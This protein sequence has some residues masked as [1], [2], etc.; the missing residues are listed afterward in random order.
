LLIYR[1][2]FR[3][4]ARPPICRSPNGKNMMVGM[5][6]ILN[7]SILVVD[8]QES[9]VSLL[10]QLLSANLI[11]SPDRPAQIPSKKPELNAKPRTPGG[12]H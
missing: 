6:D 3:V 5:P 2:E 1:L 11:V 9:N 8:D 7:A 4:A 10:E 12:A